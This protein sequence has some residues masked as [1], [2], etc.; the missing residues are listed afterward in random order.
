MQLCRRAD[1]DLVLRDDGRCGHVAPASVGRGRR[2][3]CP[4]RRCAGRRRCSQSAQW[5]HRARIRRSRARS[6]HRAARRG[7][8]RRSRFRRPRQ[9]ALGLGDS[10]AGAELAERALTGRA[11]QDVERVFGEEWVT[12]RQ[13]RVR[14]APGGAVVHLAAVRG[15]ELGQPERR[16]AAGAAVLHLLPHH[17]ARNWKASR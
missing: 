17:R 13:R 5:S 3:R 11:P 15:G 7:G 2:P 8:R 12:A 9:P 6:A 4:L 1:V 16:V 14:G 10:L